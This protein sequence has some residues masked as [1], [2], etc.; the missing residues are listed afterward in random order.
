MV[1]DSDEIYMKRCL[2][3]ALMA[4]GNTFPNPMVGAVIVH[5]GKIIGEGYH[6]KA[7][8][9]HAEPNA[10]YSVK[11]QSLLKDSTLYVSLEPCSHYGKTPPCAKLIIDKQIPRVVIACLDPNPLVSGRGVKMLQEAGIEVKTGILESEARRLNHRFIT[12]QEKHRPYV[13]LKWAQTA[14]GFIDIAR[15]D[16]GS[17]PIKISN[18]VTKTLNHQLRST[19]GAIMVATRTALLDNPH[20][21]TSKWSGNNPVRVVLDRRGIIPE[22]NKIF[23]NRAT[24]LVFTT[25]EGAEKHLKQRSNYLNQNKIK[26]IPETDKDLFFE[27]GNGIKKLFENDNIEYITIDF[28]TNIVKQILDN[29]Y[30]YN[31]QSVIIEG[32][33]MWLN[34]VINSGLWDEARIETSKSII[35]TG[36]K[37]PFI[38]G[39]EIKSEIIGDNIIRI[40]APKK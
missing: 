25:K 1:K 34:T 9:P 35:N 3:L 5:R 26:S 39:I 7:G 27:K 12:F 29:L 22:T 28:E 16:I 33:S 38:D 15:E 10:I 4:E 24:T 2:Q 11:D 31:I 14:D 21:T 6:H 20:L 36:I 18:G 37:A 40:L 32:G 19:E 23:D 17:G 13:I 8:L 30:H